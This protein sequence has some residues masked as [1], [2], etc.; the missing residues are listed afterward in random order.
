MVVL[1]IEMTSCL[2]LYSTSSMVGGEICLWVFKMSRCYR[3]FTFYLVVSC[4]IAMK[5]LHGK[6]NEERRGRAK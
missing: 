4:V 2:C 1:S 5:F 6:Q 3:F